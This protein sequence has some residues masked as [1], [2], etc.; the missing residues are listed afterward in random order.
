MAPYALLR[1]LWPA[2]LCLVEVASAADGYVYLPFS[3]PEV[4]DLNLGM[5]GSRTLSDFVVPYLVQAQV[6]TPPQN[7]SL[8]IS[9]TST[10]TWVVDATTSPCDRQYYS[11]LWSED[12]FEKVDVQKCVWGS[13]N[14]SQSSTY[15]T[16]NPRYTNFATYTFS[17]Y[18]QGSNFTDKLVVGDLTVDNYPM[19]LVDQ[20]NLR[21]GVLGLGY[22]YST[23]YGESSLYGDNL[24]GYYPTILDRMVS[25]GQISTPAY[26]IWL[27]D[28]D[29]TSG[30]LLLGAVDKSRYEGDLLR[31]D[32]DN[33]R[34]LTGKF[35]VTVHSI[36]ATGLGTGGDGSQQPLVSNALPLDVTIG[37]GELISFL[38]RDLVSNIASLAGATRDA[39]TDLYTIPCAAGTFDNATL[40][41]FTLGGEGGPLLQ[42]TT[43]DL[44]IQPGVF[45]GQVSSS[46]SASSVASSPSSSLNLPEGTCVFGIQ[47]WDDAGALNGGSYGSSSSSSASTS[48]YNLGN[49]L[50]RRTYFVFDLARQEISFA[51]AVFQS[52]SS[53][54]ARASTFEDNTDN[55]ITFTQY[56]SPSPES[57]YFCS[58][59]EYYCP[60]D[61]VNSNSGGRSTHGGAS[62]SDDGD[63]YDGRRYWRIVCIVLGVVFGTLILVGLVFAGLLFKRVLDKDPRTMGLPEEKKKLMDGGE[64]GDDELQPLDGG[65]GQGMMS[66][67]AGGGASSGGAGVLPM[68]H[69]G[70]EDD[71]GSDLPTREHEASGSAQTQ[72]QVSPVNVNCEQRL[73][74]PESLMDAPRSPSPLSEDGMGGARA[75][76]ASPVSERVNTPPNEPKGKGKAVAEVIGQAK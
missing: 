64:G 5:N 24:P 61:A 18:A 59:Y 21:M 51:P 43:A 12:E 46:E 42:A 68:I 4:K 7:F 72:A 56:G 52:S 22:N 48:Y 54:S 25:S 41:A 58:D 23:I 66:P 39:T 37:M 73:S 49:S 60:E 50:L 65:D 44:I 6:G 63:Y 76:A 11:Y 30:G 47:T 70:R 19:G 36:N 2:A 33:P 20:S 10:D 27:D 38:P 45:T 1:Q 74:V 69:E 31:L 67:A 17:G 26:S 32:A 29:G 55:I 62:S 9:P 40:F 57:Q 35:S 34:A 3:R 13:F 75:E 8:L 14:T 16:A 15:R 53:L 71:A 28:E